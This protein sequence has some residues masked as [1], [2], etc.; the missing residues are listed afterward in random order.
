MIIHCR[1]NQNFTF[2]MAPPRF[3]RYCVTLALPLPT[4]DPMQKVHEC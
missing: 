2:T 1:I 3:L 4:K